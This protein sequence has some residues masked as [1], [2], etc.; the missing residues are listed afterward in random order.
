M[1]Q[2]SRQTGIVYQPLSHVY[3]VGMITNHLNWG[4]TSLVMPK[5]ELHQFV[6]LIE[7][8]RVCAAIDRIPPPTLKFFS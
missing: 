4:V 7:K 2:L 5:F 8:F 3:G 6:R 1:D